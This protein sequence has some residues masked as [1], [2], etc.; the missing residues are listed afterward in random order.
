MPIVC[1]Y[2]HKIERSGSGQSP[3][4]GKADWIVE[5]LGRERTEASR[6]VKVEAIPMAGTIHK[7]WAFTDLLRVHARE[8]AEA[9]W[10][11]DAS[12]PEQNEPSEAFWESY[13]PL[14]ALGYAA[15][16]VTTTS[17]PGS[18]A[19]IVGSLGG[20][21][22]HSRR[23]RS[24]GGL[25]F[26]ALAAV[27]VGLADSL[28]WDASEPPP[29]VLIL[30][31]DG[32][33]GGGTAELISGNGR[34]RQIDVAVNRRDAYRSTENATLDLVARASDYV[35]AIEKALAALRP[36]ADGVRVCLYSAGVDCYEGAASGL[37]GITAEVLAER[38]RLV[39]EWCRRL[40]LR[41]AYILGGGDLSGGLSRD[42]L[43]GLHRQTIEAAAMAATRK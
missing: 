43:V 3:H 25:A 4:S 38:D 1:Y 36:A 27:A 8:Y 30:D 17:F 40:E 12:V 39:F 26:N 41:T 13:W 10:L 20:E 24:D 7:D 18:S 23:A 5:S 19:R 28:P 22:H 2:P 6:R 11:G 15:T 42:T 29:K 32:D 21:V 35:P 14:R 34:I 9:L 33:C 16:I 31:L 37:R